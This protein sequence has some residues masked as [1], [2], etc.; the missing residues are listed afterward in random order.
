M[1]SHKIK[2]WKGNDMMCGN[3]DE[4]T[5]IM[6]AS[7]AEVFSCVLVVRGTIVKLLLTASSG[8]GCVREYEALVEV[9]NGRASRQDE[10]DWPSGGDAI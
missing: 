7:G 3:D 10:V 8:C 4:E 9:Y 2:N 6:D 5:K 1:D